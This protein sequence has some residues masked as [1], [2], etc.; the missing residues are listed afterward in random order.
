[1]RTQEKLS[2]ARFQADMDWQ[3]VGHNENPYNQYTQAREYKTYEDR[4]ESLELDWD[5]AF[6]SAEVAS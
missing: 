5:Q 3:K 6:F 4:F 1:M 2:K